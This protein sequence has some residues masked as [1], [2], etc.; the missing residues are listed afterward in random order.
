MK[1]RLAI[2]AAL[3][4][5]SLLPP[6]VAPVSA[7]EEA[8]RLFLVGERAVADRFYPV[9][10]RTLERF[11]AQYPDDAR[12]PRALLMLGKARLALNDAESALEVFT[13]AGSGL[14]ATAERQDAR[15]WQAEAQFRLK[16]F[17]E[18]RAGYDEVFRADAAGPLA[19]AALYGLGRT[20]LELNNIEPAI[21]AFRDLLTT[22]PDDSAAPAATLHLARALVEARRIS[23][24]LPLL[25]TYATKF[26]GSKLIPDAQYLLGWVKYNNGDRQGG[27]GDLSAFVAANPNH[28]D[29]PAARQLLAQGLGKY[30]DRSQ[31]LQ[32]Y[33][34][35]MSLD[36]PTA[37]GY[38]DAAKIAEGLGLRKEQDDAWK[39][40][41]AQFPQD[42]LTQKMAI[43]M[44]AATFK[45][46]N[47]KDTVTLGTIAAQSDDDTV[48]AEGWLL[49]GESELKQKR[50]AQAAKAF[51]AVSGVPDVEA[52][53]R[54]RALA[55]LGLAREE[56]KEWKA[57][58][59]AYEAVATKSPDSTL[60]EWARARV[61]AVKGQMPKTNGNGAKPPAKPAE[62]PADKPPSKKS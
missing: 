47:W 19:P 14:T 28:A 43:D 46:K 57:A 49:V 30:G 35:F 3:A 34:A 50:F 29:A 7:L 45:D 21:T 2:V 20:D 18:A 44:A 10:R 4:L 36:P 24:A 15:L 62:K 26:P 58:L 38:H 41:R 32:A 5:A 25:T 59:A 48:K 33:K 39:K 8:D 16:R 17:S 12:H 9:A 42:P 55:G 52:S 22:W 60:R 51:E 61:T 37:Q 54:F 40:L 1:R 53:T 6:A 13:R 23:E 27:L 56:Q 11:V 31:R